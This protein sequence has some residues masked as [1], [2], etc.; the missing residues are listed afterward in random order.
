[1]IDLIYIASPSFSGSTM[2]T[3]LLGA[4]RSIATIGELKWGRIDL[5]TYPCSCGAL[6]KECRFWQTVQTRM[7]DR[8]LPFNLLR[9]PTD[10]RFRANP[11]ADRA[12]RARIRGPVFE[13]VRSAVVAVLPSCR[14]TRG[15]I[16]EVNRAMMEIIVDLKG[17]TMFLDASKDPVRLKHLMA[18]GCYRVR[19]VHLIRDGRAVTYSAMKNQ[20]QSAEAAALEWRRTHRQIERLACELE[21]NQKL[22]V[23]YEDLCVELEPSRRRLFQFLDL[24][25]GD[26]PA[27]FRAAEHHILGNRMRLQPTTEIR[28]D[29]K[30]R[31]QLCPADVA[32]FDRVSGAMN[33][34]YGYE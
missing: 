22:V 12:A 13:S 4:H 14:D 29:E 15:Q 30:W 3:F 19:L 10:F 27:D 26:V 24:D 1:M 8:G 32:T 33:H 17:A 5:Q 23:R 11:I 25:V 6:L 2:L 31:T 16:E 21:A 18:A 34:K 20:G 28:L 9:P 7:H